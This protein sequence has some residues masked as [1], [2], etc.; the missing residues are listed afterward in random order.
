MRARRRDMRKKL[1]EPRPTEG[2]EH[3][4]ISWSVQGYKWRPSRAQ[5][6]GVMRAGVATVVWLISHLVIP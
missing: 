3:R 5:G 6:R 2:A 1:V 4:R